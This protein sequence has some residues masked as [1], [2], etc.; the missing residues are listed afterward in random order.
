MDI[1]YLKRPSG[2]KLLLMRSFMDKMTFNHAGNAV[3][4]LKYRY[5]QFEVDEQNNAEAPHD[6][7]QLI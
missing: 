6:E 2:R 1:E 5:Q 3:S 7:T 4:L